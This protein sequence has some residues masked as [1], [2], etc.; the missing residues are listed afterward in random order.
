MSALGQKRT[1]TSART[2]SAL[3]PIAD[4]G[5]QSCDVRFVPKADSRTAAKSGLF[6]H[7]VSKRQQSRLYLEAE[8]LGSLKIDHQ[9]ELGGL[10]HW[11]VGRF[12]VPKNAGDVDPSFTIRIASAA[13]ITHQS[14]GFD[15]RTVR[16]QNRQPVTV[17]EIGQSSPRAGEKSVGK[18]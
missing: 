10:Y 17:S 7:V 16:K 5:T 2:M 14:S 15:V 11:Q 6:N 18:D 1:L 4:I 8:L 9:L 12:L 3:S 13:A